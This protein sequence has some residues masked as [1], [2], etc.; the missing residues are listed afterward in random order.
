MRVIAQL[1][2]QTIDAVATFGDFW[3][4]SALSHTALPASLMR[5]RQIRYLALQMYE[6]GTRSLPV[7]MITGMFV[8]MV[9]AVQ[10]VVQFKS[11][12]L[13][14]QLG[15]IVNLSVLR[16][17]GPVLTAILLAGRVGGAITAELGTMKVT[18][19]IDALRAM[20]VDPIRHLVAPRLAAFVVLGPFLVIYADL[21]GIFG[22]HCVSVYV[23]DINP[24]QYWHHATAAIELF[25]ILTGLIKSVLFSGAIALICCYKAFWCRPGA[26]GVGRA[27]TE[28][29]V[30]CCMVILALDFF[31]NVVLGAIYQALY[32]V[33]MVLG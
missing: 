19:Q 23:Y 4:F 26:A 9:L 5:W 32:G 8:G 16:E 31:L 1:G 7:V 28:A 2:R 25:D 13:E 24:A 12:G 18:E 17:L 3:R 10:A 20:G 11:V 33:K 14:A 22:G 27:C 30:T 6:I 15:A 21:M 29:F